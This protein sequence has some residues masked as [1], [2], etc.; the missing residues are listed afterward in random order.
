M[1]EAWTVLDERFEAAVEVAEAPQADIRV[2]S[3]PGAAGWLA[4]SGWEAWTNAAFAASAAASALMRMASAAPGEHLL[5][6]VLGIAV[7]NALIA[8][9]FLV[10]K[11]VVSLGSL[12]QL[13]SCLPTM[14][15]FGLAVRLAPEVGQWPWYSHAM[16]AAG[17]AITIAA[18]LALGSSFAVLPALRAAI[19]RGPYRIV[20]H[21]AYAGELLMALACF[22][23]RPSL[24][25]AIPWL[26][27]VPG[28][29]WRIL[30]EETL[31]AQD[32]SY[33]KYLRC[34]SWR[35]APGIW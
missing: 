2:T 35:L 8:G 12:A 17:A 15:G 20:R 11:P 26:L 14:I 13:V 31:L 4:C 16:F 30:A 10:R 34:V 28:V 24:I 23:A 22:A 3:P 25:A 1:N 21:P 19:D 29:V 33:A 32:R 27:L 18:F 7:I 6:A 5:P 9:L